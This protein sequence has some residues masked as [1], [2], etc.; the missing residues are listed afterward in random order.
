MER[1]RF[2][3]AIPES[4]ISGGGSRPPSPP[5]YCNH[6]VRAKILKIL[7]LQQITGKILNPNELLLFRFQAPWE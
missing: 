7:E 2:F 5:V 6:G 4:G 1:C 3:A